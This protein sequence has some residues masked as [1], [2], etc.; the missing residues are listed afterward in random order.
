LWISLEPHRNLGC[1]AKSVTPHRT[2]HVKEG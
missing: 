2:P 1:C